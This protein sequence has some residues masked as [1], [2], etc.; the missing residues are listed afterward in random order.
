[1]VFKEEE[2]VVVSADC[3]GGAAVA[4]EVYSGDDGVG[5]GEEAFLNFAGDFDFAVDAFA[6]GDFGG[7]IFE[8]LGVF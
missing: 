2:V 7:E 5:L 4:G 3:V 1:M 6:L 8:E